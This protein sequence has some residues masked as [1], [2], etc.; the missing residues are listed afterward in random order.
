MSQLSSILRD[1][2]WH[3][4]PGM[5]Q[6][7]GLCPLLAITTSVVNALGLA[8]ATLFVLCGSNLIVSVCRRALVRE[9]RI[10]VYVLLIASLVTASELFFNAYLPS[11]HA[12][13]GIFLPLIVTNCTIVARA[14]SFASRQPPGAALAD[15]VAHGLGFGA[16]LLVV[17][18]LRELLGTG[19]LFKGLH[20]LIPGATQDG[21]ALAG[22]GLL[23]AILPPGA[24]F[25]LALVL[26][27]RNWIE[28]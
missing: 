4:N 21:I 17:G 2:L 25:A 8:I 18:A 23:L 7:L 20:L 6:L 5:V 9:I 27:L 12:R 19:H 14:E 11:L 3:N 13:L 22:D 28:Q 15:G 16:V 26:I 24:F 10:P 1:G